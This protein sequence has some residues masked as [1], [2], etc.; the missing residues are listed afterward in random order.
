M[1]ESVYNYY[2]RE[3]DRT[4]FYNGRTKRFF[5]VSEQNSEKI[6]KILQT[7][8]TYK[9]K[10]ESFLNRM[11]AEGFILNDKDDE[12]QMMMDAYRKALHYDEY[13]LMIV[14]TF[15]C[16]L[17]CWYCY[18]DHRSQNMSE[19]T[20]L[21]VKR[22]IRKYLLEHSVKRFH[23]QWF[24]GEPLLK[25]N[26]LYDISTYAKGVC[27][28]LGVKMDC[29]ITTNS[30]LLDDRKIDCLYDCNVKF[31][32][33]AID[34]C[35]EEHNAV[36]YTPNVDTFSTALN[37]IAKIIKRMPDTYCILRINLS[38]RMHNLEKIICQID[39]IIPIEW[40]HKVCVDFQKVWQEGDNAITNDALYTMRDAAERSKYITS[41]FHH[42]ICY[43]DFKHH[44]CIFPNGKVDICDHEGLDKVGRGFLTVDGDIQWSDNLQCFKYSINNENV[45]CNH[46]KHV[47]LCGGPCPSSRN[48]M[49]EEDLKNV[50]TE[51][52][53]E[54]DIEQMIRNLCRVGI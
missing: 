8:D 25:F 3:G 17:R 33:I 11:N 7:P 22:H 13:T 10:Y 6:K 5:S 43:V 18:Q 26:I 53:F 12:Y 44:N 23:I 49:S 37:N 35:K 2:V 41:I 46:C 48:G 14:P 19:E 4:I 27:E 24:G 36:K 52:Q 1:K 15:D 38:Q 9:E 31:F 51:P 32:Q 47:L 30:L 29:N 16:N 20:V 45:I 28:E 34:G 54:T 42:G 40:R 39:E 21:R 50:C